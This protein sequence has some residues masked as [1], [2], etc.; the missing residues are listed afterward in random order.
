MKIGGFL[1]LKLQQGNFKG[2]KVSTTKYIKPYY[3]DT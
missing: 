2:I 1:M 3:T